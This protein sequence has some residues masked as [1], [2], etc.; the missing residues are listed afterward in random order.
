L[1]WLTLSGFAYGMLPTDLLA[2]EE[3][4]ASELALAKEVERLI[5]MRR[6]LQG[7]EASEWKSS[8]EWVA[9]R[10][11]ADDHG[12]DLEDA[13]SRALDE[14]QS[15]KRRLNEARTQPEPRRLHTKE[16][17][18]ILI[19]LA[20]LLEVKGHKEMDKELVSKVERKA[21][22]I[23]GGL[24]ANTVRKWLREALDLISRSQVGVEK[25][26]DV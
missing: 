25:S 23:D 1:N 26:I 19:V 11:L 12:S 18:S 10:D 21:R 17:D 9:S 3:Y 13:V 24:S 6:K 8:G 5:L 14:I 2:F 20:A 15:L 7:N 22:Y 16:Q 4:E